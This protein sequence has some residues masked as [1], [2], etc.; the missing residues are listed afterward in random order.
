MWRS[1][2]RVGTVLMVA[3]LVSACAAP[4]RLAVSPTL[5]EYSGR[6]SVSW[7]DARPEAM[8]QRSAG[9]FVLR[10]DGARSEVAVSSPLGQTLAVVSIEPGSASLVTAD[11]AVL[12]ADSPEALTERA[13]GWPAPLGRLSRWLAGPAKD[14]PDAGSPA[15]GAAPVPDPFEEAGWLVSVDTWQA[16]RPQRLTLRW[17]AAL[18]PSG[19]QTVELRLLVDDPGGAVR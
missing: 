9:R 13:F 19:A 4:P 18:A 5:Q 7:R 8:L 2:I 11:G 14:P 3:A 16:G 17:P 1:R 10:V 6:F 12:R 15:A